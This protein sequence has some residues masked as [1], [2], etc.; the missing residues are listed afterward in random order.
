LTRD[1]FLLKTFP[2]P[3]NVKLR[4]FDDDVNDPKDHP[5]WF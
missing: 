1:G 4:S 3:K 2:D 5:I